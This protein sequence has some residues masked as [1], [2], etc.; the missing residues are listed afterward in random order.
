MTP[1]FLAKLN[2][3]TKENA[4][5]Y[6]SKAG[7]RKNQEQFIENTKK[8]LDGTAKDLKHDMIDE[9]YRDCSY[10]DREYAKTILSSI[11]VMALVIAIA[12]I[13]AVMAGQICLDLAIDIVLMVVLAGAIMVTAAIVYNAVLF[14]IACKNITAAVEYAA[15]RKDID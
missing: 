4:L 9:V 7:R 14:A 15:W 11:S 2:H 13:Y 10:K 12:V 8:C 5:A 3:Q 1:I 6:Y